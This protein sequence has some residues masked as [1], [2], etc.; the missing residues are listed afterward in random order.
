MSQ[1]QSRR[2][3]VPGVSSLAKTACSIVFALTAV[4]A[5][6]QTSGQPV[7]ANIDASKTGPVISP[8]VYGQFVEH[9]GG[10]VYASLW[11]EMLDDRKFFY[12]VGPAPAPPPANAGR[13]RG[14]G[15]FG[16]GVGP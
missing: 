10:L 3:N 14:G 8:Y 7:S 5:V 13:G 4:S 16:R 6:G 11:S 1:F 2:V 9:A 15:P 12:A